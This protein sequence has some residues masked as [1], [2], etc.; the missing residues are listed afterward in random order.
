[1]KFR[2][3]IDT[4]LAATLLGSAAVSL[5]AVYVMTTTAPG[6]SLLAAALLIAIGAAL[7][8]WLL[9]ATFYAV[10]GETLRVRCGPFTW[11]IPI[12]QIL[13]VTP[14]ASVLSSPALSMDRWRIEYGNGKSLC[15]SPRDPHAFLRAL[16]I[17]SKLQPA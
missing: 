13:R 8:V 17:P 16:G 2:S 14:S 6:A 12:A 1:M 11:A 3:K 7:P 10:E 4:W 5:W 9:C 15:I